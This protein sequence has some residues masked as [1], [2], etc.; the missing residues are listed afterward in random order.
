MSEKKRKYPASGR[1]LAWLLLLALLTLVAVQLRNSLRGVLSRGE[2]SPSFTLTTFD[3][4]TI[5]SAD[6][7]GKVVLVNIWASW[8]LPCEQEAANLQTA[9]EAYADRGDVLFLGIDYVDTDKE[10]LA[11]ISKFG[12]TYPNGPD[13]GTNIFHAFHAQGVPETFVINKLGEVA[14]VKIGPFTTLDEIT[15]IIERLLVP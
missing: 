13:L 4:Q 6:L 3:D 14:A 8:C 7:Q 11:Y 10:A 1:V 15:A 2:Q 5:D 12:I 9:W